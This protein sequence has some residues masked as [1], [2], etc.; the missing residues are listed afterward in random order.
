MKKNLYAQPS[1]NVTEM[2]MVQTLCASGDSSSFSPID[3]G[4]TTDMQ[5]KS[6]Y[7]F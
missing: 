4:A 6:E 2:V 5:L 1:V 3:P 7:I